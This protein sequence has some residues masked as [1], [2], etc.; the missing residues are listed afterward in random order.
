M[1]QLMPVG[2]AT[3][4][5]GYDRLR[6]SICIWLVGCL[7]AGT[8]DAGASAYS[9]LGDLLP[10]LD[11]GGAIVEVGSDRGEGS[12]AF[13]SS[14]ANKTGRQFF[15]VDFSQQGFENAGNKCGTCAHKAMGEEWLEKAYSSIS[16]S[17]KIV[18][19]YLDN[20]DWTYP[21]TVGM[22]YKLQQRVDYGKSSQ[23]S[24]VRTDSLASLPCV[25]MY[26]CYQMQM[27]WSLATSGH[28]MC[29][30]SSL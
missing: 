8:C 21:W 1:M 26:R 29:T 2:H 25:L 13:L 27:D 17:A 18:L 23:P 22:Q 24:V 3:N 14:L 12:T 30:C 15:S 16:G 7:L 4:E 28:R 11:S 9:L 6:V 5:S 10:E 19:A 20:Y